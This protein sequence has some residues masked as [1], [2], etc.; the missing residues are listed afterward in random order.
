[1]NTWTR[2]GLVLLRV[3]IGWHFLFEGIEKLD[4]WYH[5]PREGHPEWSA[6]G[7]LRESQGPL[8]D[9]FRGQVPDPD[10]D[11][12]SQLDI[13]A[14]RQR[15]K[16]PANVADKWQKQFD[17]LISHYQLGNDKALQPEHVGYL[18]MSPIAPPPVAVPWPAIS[19]STRANV[20]AEE[21]QATLAKEDFTLAKE[22]AAKWLAMGKREVPSKIPKVEEKVTEYTPERI[23]LY[24]KKLDELNEIETKGMPAF[25]QDVWRDNLR[26][27]KKDIEKLRTELIVDLNKPFADTVNVT[28][29]R[30]SNAQAKRGPPAPEPVATTNLDRINFVTRWGTT[31]VGAC[32]ILGLF[33]R[34]SCVAGAAFLLMFYLAMPSLPW[35]PLNPRAE[36]HYFFINKNIIEM[37]ALLALAT[38][39]SGKWLGL[40]GLIQFLN[41]F[42][43]RR[44]QPANPGAVPAKAA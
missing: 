9:W 43:M 41:P 6:A 22:R 25:E 5:G 26:T 11:A 42:R 10:V 7:Y 19:R 34:I 20:K 30:L 15:D 37:V 8:A 39:P 2:I 28:K 1:M 12:L 36:G 14:R 13:P 32:L 29:A 23:A 38:T 27:L 18:A 21:L 44:A 17:D 16:L 24:K 4:S 35:L 33:T 31:I 3:V 40:D